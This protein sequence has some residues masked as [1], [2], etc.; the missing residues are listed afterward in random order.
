MRGDG[1]RP[2]SHTVPVLYFRCRET[3]WLWRVPYDERRRLFELVDREGVRLRLR[4]PEALLFVRHLPGYWLAR[5]PRR[6]WQ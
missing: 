2:W 1:L 3:S 6:R 4:L 5:E